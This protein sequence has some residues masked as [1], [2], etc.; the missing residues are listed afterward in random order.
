MSI[1]KI[2]SQ[3]FDSLKVKTVLR[4]KY[5]ETEQ[6]HTYLVVQEFKRFFFLNYSVKSVILNFTS[7]LIIKMVL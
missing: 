7:S 3:Y 1:G 2:P 5:V 6:M 4:I